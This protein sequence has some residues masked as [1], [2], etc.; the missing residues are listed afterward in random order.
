MVKGGKPDMSAI[1]M[2]REEGGKEREEAHPQT[3]TGSEE[4]NR[5]T[6]TQRIRDTTQQGFWVLLFSHM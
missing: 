6:Q 4:H 1:R 5:I 2:M 3:D